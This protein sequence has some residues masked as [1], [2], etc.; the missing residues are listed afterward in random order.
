[1]TKPEIYQLFSESLLFGKRELNQIKEY[2]KAN[3]DEYTP[4]IEREIVEVYKSYL[5]TREIQKYCPCY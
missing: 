1:M 5:R 4:E 3:I 2:I